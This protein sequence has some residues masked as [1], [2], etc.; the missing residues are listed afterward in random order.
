MWHHAVALGALP[1]PQRVSRHGEL[2]GSF[3]KT[4]VAGEERTPKAIELMSQIDPRH[5]R[6]GS[7][8]NEPEGMMRHRTSRCRQPGCRQ[9][10]LG[11]SPVF[12]R[13]LPGA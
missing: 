1:I 4:F 9:V 13:H 5:L 2:L 11:K 6:R 3:G 7:E 12:G 8:G 10:S